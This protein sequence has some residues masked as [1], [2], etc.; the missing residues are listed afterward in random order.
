M[1]ARA[2]ISVLIPDL[3]PSAQPAPK[4]TSTYTEQ[5]MTPDDSVRR[6]IDR[7]LVLTQSDLRLDE[8]TVRKFQKLTDFG[9][10]LRR[11]LHQVPEN[12]GPAEAS[13]HLLRVAFAGCSHLNWVMFQNLTY[14]AIASAIN[15]NELRDAA[16]LSICVDHTSGNA[17]ALK[18]ALTESAS[19]EQVYIAQR[20][21][22][23]SD[24]AGLRLCA[25]LLAAS[26]DKRLQ[27]LPTGAFSASLRRQTWP[28]G[29]IPPAN[30]FP[31]AIMF[32]QDERG[33][34]R[35]Y[36]M[37]EA[38]LSPERLAACF[39]SYVKCLS[40]DKSL[41][42][43]SCGPRSVDPDAIDQRAISPIITD[44][45][46]PRRLC[47]GAWALLLDAKDVATGRESRNSPPLIRYSFIKARQMIEDDTFKSDD[48]RASIEV[49]GNLMSFLAETAPTLNLASVEGRIMDLSEG[50]QMEVLDE[51]IAYSMF[52]MVWTGKK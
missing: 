28:R 40:S 27:V 31:V 36:N 6:A 1:F 12:L 19:L 7:L 11:R 15:S 50:I 21:G 51:D 23:E 9:E 44:V 52:R 42:R 18:V 43:F 17:D 4:D 46:N 10:Q 13:G 24:E 37:S 14:D 38:L 29:I 34:N 39:L 49:V 47:K 20:P 32:V 41:L 35:L 30:A 22:T 26:R 48:P 5:S 8:A 3:W 25:E 16:A 2:V 45:S 33:P